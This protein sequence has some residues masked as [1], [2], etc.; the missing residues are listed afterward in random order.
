MSGCR[1]ALEFVKHQVQ[2]SAFMMVH[3]TK[4]QCCICNACYA[5]VKC[6]HVCGNRFEFYSCVSFVHTLHR[7]VKQPSQCLTSSVLMVCVVVAQ[8]LSVCRYSEEA[9]HNFQ[10]TLDWLEEHACSRS[11]GLGT[12]IPWDEQYLIESL[13]DSTIYMSY[14]TVAHLLQGGVVDGSKVGPLGIRCVW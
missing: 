4:Q 5:E 1:E 2:L 13:S 6:V 14:Y 3:N 8:C 10:G 7:I 9:R 12:R 11:F